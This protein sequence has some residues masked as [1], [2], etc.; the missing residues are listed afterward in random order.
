MPGSGAYW[1]HLV[2]SWFLLM[3]IISSAVIFIEVLNIATAYPHIGSFSGQV[4]LLYEQEP[5]RW[6][7][8]YWGMFVHR[9][10]RHTMVQC[11]IWSAVYAMW[12]RLC[13]RKEVADYYLMLH[14]TGKRNFNLDR[15]VNSLL[16]GGDND[17]AMCACDIGMSMGVFSSSQCS[18]MLLVKDLP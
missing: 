4:S 11:S 10:F 5:P 15:S 9:V 6:T 17:L 7:K 2:I 12:S 13:V 8:R 14:E 3:M 18:I 16:S 1:K